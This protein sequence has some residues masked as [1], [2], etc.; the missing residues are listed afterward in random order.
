MRREPHVRFREGGGLKF[1][2]ATR[3]APRQMFQEIL[4]IDSPAA[5]TA[6]TSMTMGWARPHV[7]LSAGRPVV[8]QYAGNEGCIG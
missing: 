6:R 7:R 1:P 4:S 2:S 3:P 5:G 8:S